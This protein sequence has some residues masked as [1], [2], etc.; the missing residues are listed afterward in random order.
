M[1]AMKLRNVLRDVMIGIL[2]LAW[3]LFFFCSSGGLMQILLWVGT[4]VVIFALVALI[5]WLLGYR[6]FGDRRQ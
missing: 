1:K 2:W 6:V 3:I 4:N 5:A